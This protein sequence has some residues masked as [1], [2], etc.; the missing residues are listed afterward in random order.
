MFT[1]SKVSILIITLILISL[2]ACGPNANASPAG[3]DLDQE[4]SESD[5]ASL[6]EEGGA[7]IYYHYKANHPFLKIVSEPVIGLVISPG[8]T[9][10][11]FD[12]TGIGETRATLEMAAGVNN[13]ECWIQCEMTLRYTVDS[14]IEL[15]EVN[16]DC[17]IPVT[18]NFVADNDESILTGDCPDQAMELTDCAA[19]SLVM[20]D[21]S[22]Y[23]FTKEIRDLDLPSAGG[24]TLRAE[25]RNVKMPRGTQGI[26]NW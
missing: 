3:D 14:K 21:P 11:S 26:C 22:L 20:V 24:V 25:I 23:T 4:L 1:R 6:A 16:G 8:G 18:F 12:V 19:L 10:G 7:T 2:T 17:K 13:V 9:P 15:D 5:A